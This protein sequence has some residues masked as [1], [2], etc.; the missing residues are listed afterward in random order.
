MQE[1]VLSQSSK[2]AKSP[3]ILDLENVEAYLSL[4][5]YLIVI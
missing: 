2:I 4:G 5:G 1:M 3:K